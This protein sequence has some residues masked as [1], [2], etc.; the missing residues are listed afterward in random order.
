[1]TNQNRMIRLTNQSTLCVS[2]AGDS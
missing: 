1:L 2:E